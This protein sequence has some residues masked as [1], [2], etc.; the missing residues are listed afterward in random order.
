MILYNF[1][2][3]KPNFPFDTL[4]YSSTEELVVGQLVELSIKDTPYIGVVA[5]ISNLKPDQIKNLRPVNI[6]F[7]LVLTQTHIEYLNKISFLTYNSFNNLLIL[8]IKS[9]EILINENIEVRRPLSIRTNSSPS[10][11]YIIS[12]DW[13]N[14][15]QDIINTNLSTNDKYLIIS[16]ESS[17]N[18]KLIDHL[19]QFFKPEQ[20][21]LHNLKTVSARKLRKIYS[22]FYNLESI[23]EPQI[24]F[25]NKNEL[26]TDLS[27]INTMIIVD[28]GNP[29]YIN[30]QRT[31]FDTREIAYWASK[32]Y[33]INLV[34][35]STL[36]SVRFFDMTNTDLESKL[37]SP[38][39]S[40]KFLERQSRQEDFSN[41][42]LELNDSGIIFGDDE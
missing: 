8:A 38:K 26:F 40:F 29:S 1:Y 31:Y 42:L 39:L 9:F 30:E 19:E 7:N 5:G 22:S 11:E 41:I 13:G 25:A 35:I 32:I 6:I 28:E 2:I 27:D 3:P 21:T 37:K 15:I 4:T 18:T 17:I 36:P 34:F 10:L 12:K 20:I 23:N 14:A 24:Y 16:P 33:N